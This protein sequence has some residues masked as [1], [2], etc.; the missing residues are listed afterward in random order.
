MKA[1]NPYLWVIASKNFFYDGGWIQPE[2][3]LVP[4][5]SVGN[6]TTGG[7]GKT[8]FVLELIDILTHEFT[9]K[10]ILVIS[11][12]Y[13]A[14]L[15]TPAEITAERI[16]ETS[17]YG[18][19]PCLIKKSRPAVIVWS[20]PNKAETLKAALRYCQDK[21]QSIDVVIVDDG[22]S[23]RKIQRNLDLVLL[24]S[25][26]PLSHY[27]LLPFGHLREDM[28]QLLR[29]QLVV[30]TKTNVADSET[31][32]WLRSYLGEKKI[33]YVESTTASNIDSIA[34]NVFLFSGIGNP[35]QL[36]NNLLENGFEVVR[37]LIYPDHAK[38]GESEQKNILEQWKK[39]PESILATTEKDFIKL[40]DSELKKA[41]KI[42]SLNLL[43]SAKGKELLH[44][45]ISSIF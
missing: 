8:P 36:K 29:S 40:T 31:L 1:L 13:K 45:K 41:T 42:I 3:F 28:S 34:K 18:D 23:H 6:I 5:I 2:K 21:N 22:F 17:I 33:A 14:S 11:K 38:Y 35:V 32:H 9:K 10:N 15:T 37:H 30:L 39:Y 24:D 44:E 20:G 27:Q 19:E 26:Q 7:T 25:S 43:L 16:I 4:V 12:S